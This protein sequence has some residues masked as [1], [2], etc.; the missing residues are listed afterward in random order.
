MTSVYKLYSTYLHTFKLYVPIATHQSPDAPMDCGQNE[1]FQICIQY[2]YSCYLYTCVHMYLV[3]MQEC[4]QLLQLL[5]T[6][7]SDSKQQVQKFELQL[8]QLQVA[9]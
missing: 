3:I 7:L 9:T 2:S 1:L 8:Q 4:L 5:H 6:E